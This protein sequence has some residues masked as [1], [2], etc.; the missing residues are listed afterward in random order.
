MFAMRVA[1]A[2]AGAL[3]V[4]AMLGGCVPDTP[5]TTPAP[6]PSATPV[7]ASDEEAQAAAEAA[8]AAYL[9]VSDAISADG[10]ANPERIEPLVSGEQYQVE[11]DG[12]TTYSAKGW[13]TI[14]STTFDTAQL[15][16]YAD[17]GDGTSTVSIY[18][19]SDT[20]GVRLLDSTGSDITPSDSAARRTL[21]LSF[22]NEEPAS[23]L[24]L[25]S[26]GIWN[27][28]SEC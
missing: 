17:Y 6:E 20:T 27:S 15:Q 11:L 2:L 1:P 8:Y 14:G 21:E 16:A 4:L 25:E 26:A 10:G 7:F 9:A 19:C 28:E 13:K 5:V 22:S 24:V 18:V 12:F 3:V 23:P